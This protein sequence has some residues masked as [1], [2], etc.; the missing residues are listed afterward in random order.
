MAPRSRVQSPE[1]CCALVKSAR[2]RSLAAPLV[3]GLGAPAGGGIVMS[4]LVTGPKAVRV[5]RGRS[6]SF[7]C[8]HQDR[9]LTLADVLPG[10]PDHVVRGDPIDLPAVAFQEIRRVA[11]ELVADLLAQDLV[12]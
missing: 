9:D 3:A 11:V 2:P 5:S 7:A 10:D 12:A 8:R 6:K 4:S 1:D